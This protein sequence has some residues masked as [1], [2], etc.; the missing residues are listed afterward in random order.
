M[1]LHSGRSWMGIWIFISFIGLLWGLS[2][3]AFL[4]DSVRNLNAISV[5][6]FWVAIVAGFQ[7]TLAMRKADKNDKF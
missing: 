1:D 5:V 7:S 2:T 6:T 3:F 4:L